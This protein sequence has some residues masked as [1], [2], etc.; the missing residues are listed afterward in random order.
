MTYA[1]RARKG[2]VRKC[3]SARR[4]LLRLKS[5]RRIKLLTKGNGAGTH[6][7]AMK[8]R[9]VVR[10]VLRLPLTRDLAVAVGADVVRKLDGATARAVRD[11]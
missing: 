3:G 2:A 4:I 1:G 8:G 5:V 7:T 11:V 6:P 10:P 9:D